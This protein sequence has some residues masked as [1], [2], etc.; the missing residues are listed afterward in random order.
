MNTDAGAPGIAA[1]LLSARS[2]SA[3][4]PQHQTREPQILEGDAVARPRCQRLLQRR[5]GLARVAGH[6]VGDA[7]QAERIGIARR[8]RQHLLTQRA[9]AIGIA[10]LQ[11]LLSL[12]QLAYQDGRHG[13]S[14]AGDI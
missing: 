13:V 12:A 1:A 14:A 6:E 7:K 2:A 8:A 9:R 3:N 11:A 10:R 4:S 5:D